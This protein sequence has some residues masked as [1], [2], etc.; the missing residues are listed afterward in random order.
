[1]HLEHLSL[2]AII[3]SLED[4]EA[5]VAILVGK[6]KLQ[7]LSLG[8]NWWL[9]IVG[10]NSPLS[11]QHAACGTVALR[12][13]HVN[14]TN[15]E[16]GAFQALLRLIKPDSLLNISCDACESHVQSDLQ[17]IPDKLTRCVENVKIGYVDRLPYNPGALEARFPSLMHLTLNVCVE[18]DDPLDDA[19]LGYSLPDTLQSLLLIGTDY[20]VLRYLHGELRNSPTRLP[21]LKR[22]EIPVEYPTVDIDFELR[23][24]VARIIF[25]LLEILEA[26]GVQVLP[27]DLRKQ[28]GLISS[29]SVM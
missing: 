4:L 12:T 7:T 22:V 5:L 18:L 8:V 26:R 6:P 15:L 17:H 16:D 10:P 20:G 28:W 13:L 3:Y 25:E 24:L 27:A 1:V 23:D 9:R 19:A 14:N 11:K 29:Q 21:K 2:N